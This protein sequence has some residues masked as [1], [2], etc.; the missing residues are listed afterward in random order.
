MKLGDASA[1]AVVD[2]YTR[3]LACGIV[4]VINVFQP[5]VLCVG[6]GISREGDVLLAPVRLIADREDYARM[7]SSRTRIVQ[8]QLG[9]DAGLYGAAALPMHS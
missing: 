1:R 7:L 5:Q 2:R 4:N 9:S 3:Y 6:G 8:A